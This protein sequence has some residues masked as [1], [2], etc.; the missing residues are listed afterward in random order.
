MTDQKTDVKTTN[1]GL[2]QVV[3][4]PKPDMANVLKH[5]KDLE[6][7]NTKWEKKV[8]GWLKHLILA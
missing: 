5:I 3:D 1:D 2:T 4:G 7:N 6:E 8:A